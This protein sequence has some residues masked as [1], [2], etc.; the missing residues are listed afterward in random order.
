MDYIDIFIDD[1]SHNI[2]TDNTLLDYDL[3]AIAFGYGNDKNF[4]TIPVPIVKNDII[5]TTDDD[6]ENNI[7]VQATLDVN[8]SNTYNYINSTLDRYKKYRMN[9]LNNVD[10]RYTYNVLFLYLYLRRY[11]LLINLC[12]NNIGG[13]MYSKD[14]TKF[15]LLDKQYSYKYIELLLRIIDELKYSDEEMS[16]LTYKI[17]INNK[18]ILINVKNPYNMGSCELYNYYHVIVKS[19][20]YKILLLQ[21]KIHDNNITFLDVIDKFL[22]NIDSKY[23]G[24]FTRIKQIN[25]LWIIELFIN[26]LLNNKKDK[27][28]ESIYITESFYDDDDSDMNISNKD[29]N[30]QNINKDLLL[31]KYKI[32]NICTLL[33]ND[34][35]LNLSIK[36][37]IQKMIELL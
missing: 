1:D 14:R 16:K 5:F 19:I 25:E 8:D 33:S 11:P 31:I 12:F 23:K 20:M 13:K 21:Q 35:K 34:E 2:L 36:I 17:E 32:K 26:Q 9:I 37:F 18:N 10:D 15:L 28:F 6:I 3:S 27:M 24:I 4:V 29:R 7:N 22:F 30:V